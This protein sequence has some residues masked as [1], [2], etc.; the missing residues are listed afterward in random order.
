VHRPHERRLGRPVDAVSPRT[1]RTDA[2]EVSEA[3]GLGAAHSLSE[4]VARGELGEI[5]RLQTEH[6]TFAV[7]Q[8]IERL[9]ADELARVQ[10]GAAYQR[11]CW[12]A[13]IPTPEPI[14]TP[15]G[16]FTAEIAGEHLMAY[17]WVDLEE[18]DRGLDPASLGELLARVHAVHRPAGGAV[19]PWFEAPIGARRWKDALK[20]SRAAGAPYA[21]R[22]ADLLSAIVEV[23]AILTPMAPVQTCHLD[24]WSD[25]LRLTTTGELCI[26]DFDNAGPGD[27]S[28]E[29]AMLLFEFG[30]G[31]S[32]RQRRLYDAYR[33]ADGPGRVNEPAD[34]AMT[35]AQLQHIGHRHLT[36]WLAARDREARARS[37]AGVEEFLG[38]PFLLADVERIVEALSR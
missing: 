5:R 16:R 14:Q 7:K 15:S 38:E 20:A 31:D 18:P 28:R 10:V 32:A 6:G 33:A 26:F 37:L 29:L 22:L 34:F 17:S 13:G 8:A 9:D 4:P 30:Q 11:A 3:F 1:G 21:D 19:H 36:M 24:L 25:N 23:E 27:P 35:V 2:D 12:E